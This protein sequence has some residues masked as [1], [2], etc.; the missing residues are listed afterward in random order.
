MKVTI[1]G[2]GIVGCA[3]A[4][5]LALRGASVV[6]IDPRGIG[7][8]ATRASAGILA[9]AIE[10]HSTS[11]RRLLQCGL[12]AYD[13]FVRRLEAETGTALEYDRS[14][15]LQL[16]LDE[17]EATEL[18]EMARQLSGMNVPHQW[19]TPPEVSSLEPTTSARVTAALSIPQHGYVA[20][21]PLLGHLATAMSKRGVTVE[22]EVVTALERGA[23]GT[24]VVTAARTIESDAVVVA[25]GSWSSSV[26]DL[27]VHPAPVRPIRGQLLRLRAPERL[28][29]RVLW[30]SRC[31]VV[32]WRDGSM[33]VG[34]TVEDVGFDETATTAGVRQLL[35]A[36]VE[37]LPALDRATFEEVR[38]GL[39]PM[40]SDELPVIGA[41]SLMPRLF[42]ATGH[43]RNGVLLAPFTAALVADLV[44]D[45]RE[46][47]E[48]S[49]TRP[50]RLRM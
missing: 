41:S 23:A 43:Y 39:R 32:P 25:A 11:L 35:D 29:S 10:G 7:G 21:G 2:A 47:E 48:L 20:V 36:S 22:N 33:L 42:Y 1:V 26:A 28:A 38:V 27:R 19:L 13:G 24:R 3:I 44:V 9:P 40:A 17:A 12:E 8:G 30:G 49:I 50:G 37:L 34:A 4:H 31:Y 45:G 46:R 18:E 6:V 5:E 16:A 15:T 14:G